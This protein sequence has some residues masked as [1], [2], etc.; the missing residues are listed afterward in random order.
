MPRTG[1]ETLSL[2]AAASIMCS[3]FIAC[4]T[5]WRAWK[6]KIKTANNHQGKATLLSR[7]DSVTCLMGL[8]SHLPGEWMW[9]LRNLLV[10]RAQDAM[11]HWWKGK[12][13]ERWERLIENRFKGTDMWLCCP[14]GWWKEGGWE[15]RKKVVFGLFTGDSWSWWHSLTHVSRYRETNPLVHHGYRPY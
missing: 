6:G 2:D 4:L 8:F 13:D 12:S 11:K 9:G 10:W 1:P 5:A 15:P 14:S 7:K 3:F